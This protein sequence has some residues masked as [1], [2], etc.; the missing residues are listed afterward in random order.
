MATISL[1]TDEINTILTVLLTS[2]GVELERQLSV[3]RICYK[4]IK[5]VSHL[6]EKRQF[7]ALAN[8]FIDTND[9]KVG[10]YK[11]KGVEI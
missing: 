3:L 6:A 9:L 11:F 5:E 1:R 7:K 4:L 2:N 8:L 10:K